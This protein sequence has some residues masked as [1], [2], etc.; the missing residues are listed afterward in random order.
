MG[1]RGQVQIN[2]VYLY[3]HWGASELI[4]NV[5][6]AI[7]KRRRWDDYEY[8]TRIIFDVMKGDDTTSET[9]FGIGAIGGGDEGNTQIKITK[10]N[11]ITIIKFGENIFKGTF[12]EFLKWKEPI[13]E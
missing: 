9:G 12:E 4:E 11:K 6:K 3:T 13:E 2:G 5:Q 8:L 10:N 1:D 7:R